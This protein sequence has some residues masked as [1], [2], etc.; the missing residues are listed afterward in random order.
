M[1]G[2][3][4]IVGRKDFTNN[5]ILKI[6]KRLEYRGYDSYG[7]VTDSGLIK[8]QIGEISFVEGKDSGRF[9]IAIAHTRW[10]THGGVAEENAH[11]HSDCSNNIF[12]VHNGI[13]ENYIELKNELESKGHEFTSETDSEVIAHY[14]EEKLKKQTMEKSIADFFRDAEG[15]FAVLLFMLG[16]DKIYAF[17]RDSP[18]VLGLIGDGYVLASDI[19]AFADKT[20]RAIFFDDNE[21]AV[22]S[23]GGYEFF[24]ARGKKTRKKTQKFEWFKDEHKKSFDHFM[25]KEIYDEPAAVERLL[26]SLS[27]TQKDKFVVL[28]KAIKKHRKIVFI[29]SGTSYHASLIGVYFLQKAGIDAY[30]I[31]ASEFRDYAKI[32][33]RTLV[34]AVS[35]SGET[36]DVIDA[37][38]HAKEKHA[39]IAS[40]VNTPYS[41]I[42]R[43]SD[44][45]IEI[46][47]GQEVCV[48]A[49]KT[50]VNQVVLF[51]EIAKEFGYRN[52]TEK[53]PNAIRKLLD[54]EIR[55]K[56]LAKNLK[57]AR[58][59]YIIGR[60]ISYPVAR[61]IALKL[62]EIS[63][64]HAE[65]MMGGELKH[66]TLALIEKNTPVISLMNGRTDIISNTK[67]VEARG[68]R[69]IAF[70]SHG[71]EY[72]DFIEIDAEDDGSFAVLSAIAGQL[73]TYHIARERGLAIDKPRN[74]A[75]SVTVK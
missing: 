19:Y 4:G 69:V 23:T 24:N 59:I 48:A 35:Q 17:R 8:K 13:I 14:F 26:N 25:L 12:I 56:K 6:L 9:R 50:F 31:I 3:I 32:N 15:T 71:T 30:T 39:K 29:A 44:L 20:D 18:L 58:D 72:G 66:G 22:I 28:N 62:K 52:G 41:T 21:F 73:L 53:M 65:G 63:Y 34:V 70:T 10:A 36:M 2:I 11:P 54:M 43:M 46:L 33:S 40:I 61:E 16:S 55:I 49:T 42:Q 51:L 64:I 68:A 27:T 47:A 67:E 1:C 38:K 45:S 7:F 57:D 75:K 60:G 74:L 5:D 37:L